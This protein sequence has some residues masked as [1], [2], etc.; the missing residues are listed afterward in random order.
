M[1]TTGYDVPGYDLDGNGNIS[2]A[3]VR[4]GWVRELPFI[5]GPFPFPIT[6]EI[7]REKYCG[8]IP[9][10]SPENCKAG[11]WRTQSVSLSL[12]VKSRSIPGCRITLAERGSTNSPRPARGRTPLEA[13]PEPP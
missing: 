3:W 9:E 7:S 5:T 1:G 10:G 8:N 11:H 13:S 4:F 6:L 12:R 2:F